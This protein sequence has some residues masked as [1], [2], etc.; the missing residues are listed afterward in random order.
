[1]EGIPREYIDAV[2]HLKS[3]TGFAPEIGLVLGSGLGGL[4]ELFEVKGKIKYSEIPNFP[5]STVKGHPGEL[6][7][8][9]KEGKRIAVLAGRFHYYEGYSMKEITFPIRVLA[10]WGVKKLIITNAAGGVN[11]RFRPGDIMLI[12][13][14]INLLPENPLRGPNIDA[15][16]PRFPSLHDVYS[17]EL[18]G[19]AEEA[20]LKAGV[21]LRRG[22]YVALQGP[23]LET[24]AEYSF[25]RTIG[26]DAV[27]MS[28]VPEVIVAN[29]MGVKVLG[30]SIITN[31]ANPYSPRP[32]THEEV[33]E[34]A[35]VATEKLM[36][37]IDELLKII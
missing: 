30:F 36:R 14:H 6:V 10:L 20:A 27:G 7:Y 8:G 33:L 37:V 9:E 15:F 4:S 12:E 34:V 22:V 18:R 25:V 19:K 35:G 16:G 3:K 32:T 23:D 28:T 13:D 11:P 5:V 21:S 29:H 31:L 26:G 24:P 17:R 1:M 2:E